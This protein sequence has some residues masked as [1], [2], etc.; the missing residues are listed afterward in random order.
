V[1]SR[2]VVL[3][4]LLRKTGE[5]DLLALCVTVLLDVGLGALEDIA[6]LLLAGRFSLLGLGSALLACLLLTL[7]LLEEGLWDKD[8]LLG[9]DGTKSW[10]ALTVLSNKITA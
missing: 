10:S 7:A 1:L 2:N 5:S 6:T 3:A 9:R 4:I 8:D